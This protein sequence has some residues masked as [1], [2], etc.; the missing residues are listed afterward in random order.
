MSLCSLLKLRDIPVLNK[1]AGPGFKTHS[2][3]KKKKLTDSQS[4]ALDKNSLICQGVNEEITST[5]IFKQQ[6]ASITNNAR[7]K[8]VR[9]EHECTRGS[10]LQKT[11]SLTV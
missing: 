1:G 9:Q 8:L 11:L 10:P 4:E 2:A 3:L 5:E 7:G 6:Y